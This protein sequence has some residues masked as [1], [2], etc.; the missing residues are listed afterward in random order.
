MFFKRNEVVS[1]RRPTRAAAS[2]KRGDDASV[3]P[4]FARLV[5]ESWWFVVVAAII[6]LALILATYDKTD[7]GWSF[8]GGSDAIVNRGGVAGA[9]LSDLLLYL[10]GFSAWWLVLAGLALIIGGYRRIRQSEN[11]SDHPLPL[12]A[13]GFGLVLLCSA[14]LEALRFYKLP[15]TLPLGS[16]GALGEMI[17]GNRIDATRCEAV[18]QHFGVPGLAHR[19]IDPQ[20]RPQPRHIVGSQKTMMG[21]RL[22]RDVHSSRPP[23]VDRGKSRTR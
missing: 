14:A 11:E 20:H 10:F 15:V 7:R 3:S 2:A 22:A 9:W 23:R 4:R 21:G 19:R 1:R 18:Q 5:R 12:A 6:W 8:S 16:G 13:F 17:G